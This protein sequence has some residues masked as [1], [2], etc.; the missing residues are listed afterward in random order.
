MEQ[1]M[2]IHSPSQAWERVE[3]SLLQDLGDV[4]SKRDDA[5]IAALLRRAASVRCPCPP[6]SIIDGVIDSLEGFG[7]EQFRDRGEL[8]EILES[9]IGAGDLIVSKDSSGSEV[10]YLGPPRFVAR[11]KSLILLGGWPD[12]GLDIPAP[13]VGSLLS[14]GSQRFI[15]PEDNT[16]AQQ[17]LENYGYLSYPLD[18]W[19]E[20]PSS[21]SA[22]DLLLKV[23]RALD[24]VGRAG[25]IPQ[26]LVLDHGKQEKYYKGRWTGAKSHSGRFVARRPQR[27]GADL[28]SYVEIADGSPSKVVDLPLIDPRFR[29]C[30]E[31]WWLQCAIDADQGTPQEVRLDAS[32]DGR[33]T[34]TVD[35]PF[36]SWAVRQI[37]LVG[38]PTDRLDGLFSYVTDAQEAGD[39]VEFLQTNLWCRV[40]DRTKGHP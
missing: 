21:R 9:L 38:E 25:D 40:I 2:T 3:A 24:S 6:R 18:S 26:L 8:G 11:K 37:L 33:R 15:Q 32:D 30:D 5:L 22:K 17:E 13:L 28:W 20:R 27:W 1:D 36:P 35:M 29:G 19:Q 7:Q 12:T 14:R 39:V 23:N 4:A 10:L 31:A 16:A 34:F